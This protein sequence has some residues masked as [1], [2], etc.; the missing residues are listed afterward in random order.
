[1]PAVRQDL[2]DRGFVFG[3]QPLDADRADVV[4]RPHAERL[5]A[6]T[7]ACHVVNDRPFD[8][9]GDDAGMGELAVAGAGQKA[10]HREVAAP[11][12]GIAEPEQD[13]TVAKDFLA[14][15]VPRG[16]VG[17]RDDR[18]N[19]ALVTSPGRFRAP[20]SCPATRWRQPLADLGFLWRMEQQR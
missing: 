6:D 13:I 20:D 15:A 4:E 16:H 12:P 18:R 8:L 1:M 10:A 14:P 2:G 7:Q 17:G 9:D 11:D 5:P 19:L 3:T